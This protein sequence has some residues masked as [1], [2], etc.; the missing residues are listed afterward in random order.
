MSTCAAQRQ[1]LCSGGLHTAGSPANNE[2]TVIM[3]DV[4]V[5]EVGAGGSHACIQADHSSGIPPPSPIHSLSILRPVPLLYTKTAHLGVVTRVA[6]ATASTLTPILGLRPSNEQAGT[7]RW[8]WRRRPNEAVGGTNKRASATDA[9]LRTDDARVH[10]GAKATADRSPVLLISPVDSGGI[11]R[12]SVD[13]VLQPPMP[14]R[15][16]QVADSTPCL[17]APNAPSLA[18][19]FPRAPKRCLSVH[20][21]FVAMQ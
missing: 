1:S 16:S 8:W 10:R 11:R 3:C 21:P 18:N 7:S 19:S 4:A 5:I 14:L 20:G 12:K 6:D 9:V 17:H 13:W 2:S 15:F